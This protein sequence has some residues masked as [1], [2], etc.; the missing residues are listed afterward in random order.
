[1]VEGVSR[2][3]A[4]LGWLKE[5]FTLEG[6]AVTDLIQDLEKLPDNPAECESGLGGELRMGVDYLSGRLN[7]HGWPRVASALEEVFHPFLSTLQQAGNRGM[8]ASSTEVLGDFV[9]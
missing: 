4:F 9:P 6:G 7:I 8:E 1:M 5:H 2:A 3:M